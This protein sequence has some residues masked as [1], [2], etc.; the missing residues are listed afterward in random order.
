MGKEGE[1]FL[2]YLRL[3]SKE[4]EKK[5]KEGGHFFSCM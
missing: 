2:D 3:G 4:K 1:M 5:E